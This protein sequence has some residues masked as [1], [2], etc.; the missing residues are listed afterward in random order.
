MGI[1]PE[2]W[3]GKIGFWIIACLFIL[4]TLVATARAEYN[5]TCEQRGNHYYCTDM[6]S[7]EELLDLDNDLGLEIASF[8]WTG[9]N[10]VGEGGDAETFTRTIDW[11]NKVQFHGFTLA[12][13]Y[14]QNGNS[15][16]TESGGNGAV[17]T[18]TVDATE[19]DV[20]GAITGT[21]G[22]AGHGSCSVSC[23][24]SPD[25]DSCGAS[26]GNGGSVSILLR[27]SDQQVPITDITGITLTAGAGGNADTGACSSGD[28]G[29]DQGLDGEN[30]GNLAL[31]LPDTTLGNITVTATSADGGDGDGDASSGGED[32][33]NAD[34]GVGGA[35]GYIYLTFGDLILN[36]TT[37]TYVNGL[38]GTGTGEADCAGDYCDTNDCW[39]SRDGENAGDRQLYFD[40]GLFLDSTVTIKSGVGS[41]GEG[42]Y[43]TSADDDHANYCADGGDGGD[44]RLSFDSLVIN[45]STVDIEAGL[46]GA[47]ETI[48]EGEECYGGDTGRIYLTGDLTVNSGTTVLGPTTTPATQGGDAVQYSL[49]GTVFEYNGGTFTVETQK[50]GNCITDYWG[51]T[52]DRRSGGDGDRLTM[53][54][55]NVTFLES[56][57]HLAGNSDDNNCDAAVAGQAG[58]VTLTANEYFYVAPDKVINL[59]GGISG[60]DGTGAV[61][62]TT[63]DGG[64][65]DVNLG[66]IINL[67]NASIYFTGGIGADDG[68]VDVVMADITSWTADGATLE[69]GCNTPA[70]TCAYNNIYMSAARNIEFFGDFD[71]TESESTATTYSLN[72]S[73]ADV[74]VGFDGFDTDTETLDIY[75]PDI[76][77]VTRLH[78]YTNDASTFNWVDDNPTD[79]P[80]LI[81]F[82]SRIYEIDL[83]TDTALLYNF[84]TYNCTAE[85]V[86]YNASCY[87]ETANVSTDCG[88]DTGSYT[89]SGD[90]YDAVF[91]CNESYDGIWDVTNN[92]AIYGAPSNNATVYINYTKPDWAV[93]DSLW[94]VQTHNGSEFITFN[95]SILDSCWDYNETLQL[96]FDSYLDTLA[97]S[98]YQCNN[99]SWQL[100]HQISGGTIASALMVEEGMHWVSDVTFNSTITNNPTNVTCVGTVTDGLTFNNTRETYELYVDPYPYNLSIKTG[101]YTYWGDDYAYDGN[102]NTSVSIPLEVGNIN[103][104][105]QNVCTTTY[106][107][108]PV[109]IET[110]TP[111][112]LNITAVNVTYGVD[113][114][115]N[116]EF[117]LSIKVYSDTEGLLNLTEPEFIYESDEQTTLRVRTYYQEPAGTKTYID[118]RYIN[119][120]YSEFN[121]SLPTYMDYYDVFPAYTGQQAVQPWGQTKTTPIWTV[122][123]NNRNH[124]FLV[125]AKYSE[126]TSE[127]CIDSYWSLDNRLTRASDIVMNESFVDIFNMTNN[128]ADQI[129]GF[130]DFTASCDWDDTRM[131]FPEFEFRSKCSDCVCTSDLKEVGFCE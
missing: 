72:V 57:T 76:T 6:P 8:T 50:G 125:R 101:T 80:T 78:N 74:W 48:G 47:Q 3:L 81:Q 79:E 13:G 34:V 89:C 36:D 49:S 123:P 45:D 124:T 73:G 120:L 108:V 43:D 60:D 15:G 46:G 51:A 31:T 99:G 71:I 27:A 22:Y 70:A 54:Y 17:I 20:D 84:S 85:Y 69:L 113:N 122:T 91:P 7:A 11:D 24:S 29:A 18:F 58:R 21:A 102:F 116:N 119:V 64:L 52:E 38:P 109:L 67:T 39:D 97:Y 33:C 75:T 23:G 107:Q 30:G 37:M 95:L 118:D 127:S 114:L 94:M 82:M 5:A 93:N 104:Y 32:G 128:T 66:G 121:L 9:A 83:T 4:A 14:G 117:N 129:W 2:T 62:D 25:S 98:D 59:T 10:G 65:V 90:F 88:L 28:D 111:A 16:G 92:G 105:L 131:F 12:G 55:D 35:D 106:C 130:H 19:I 126:N 77:D 100:L 110:V 44:I 61:V 86:L 115:T 42:D 40:D 1:M 26:G 63:I 56:F 103:H 68:Y 41:E 112:S 96:R 87:Q 53:T